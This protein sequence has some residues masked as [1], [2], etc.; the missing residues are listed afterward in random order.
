[1]SPSATLTLLCLS[2]SKRSMKKKSL[3]GGA[4]PITIN[5][6]VKVSDGRGSQVADSHL[7]PG[8]NVQSS[9]LMIN[10]LIIEH[11]SP[12]LNGHQ[13]PEPVGHLN[14]MQRITGNLK[15]ELNSK[16]NRSYRNK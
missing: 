13:P 9:N 16:A 6:V 1:M 5:Y 4:R 2:N 3:S 11:L 10:L 12:G 8:S 7:G 15:C 14:T